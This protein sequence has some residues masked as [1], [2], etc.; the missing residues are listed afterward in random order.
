MNKEKNGIISSGFA[1][2]RRLASLDTENRPAETLAM[3]AKK[4]Q[5]QGHP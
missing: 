5:K 1:M 3:T 4:E 2:K